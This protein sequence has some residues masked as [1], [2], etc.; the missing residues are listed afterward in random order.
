ME[1]YYIDK[2]SL[3]NTLL[4]EEKQVRFCIT[5]RTKMSVLIN[6]YGIN[7]QKTMMLRKKVSDL[8]SKLGRIKDLMTFT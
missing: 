8:T 5:Y 4:T 6:Y 7:L 1:T 3:L 2:L